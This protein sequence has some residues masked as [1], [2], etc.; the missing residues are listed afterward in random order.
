MSNGVA[1]VAARRRDRVCGKPPAGRFGI[2]PITLGLLTYMLAVTGCQ[3]TPSSSRGDACT[4]APGM[5]TDDL[6]RC[7]C[8]PGNSR[9]DGSVML[10]S[11]EALNNTRTVAIINYMCPLGAAGVA[12]VAVMN[13]VA[14]T[15][16][17]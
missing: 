9:G 12:R 14:T 13:G 4:F 7:G 1:A 2:R 11:E 10:M 17:E 15:V 3:S 5:T 8:A 6:A 16:Y